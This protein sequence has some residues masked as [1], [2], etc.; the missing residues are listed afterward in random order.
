[1]LEHRRERSHQVV[2]QLPNIGNE[3]TRTALRKLNHARL[4]RLVE[5][6]HIEPVRRRIESLAF[7]LEVAAHEREASG[8]RLAHH[9]DVVAR[10][11]HRHPELQRLDGPLLS[12]HAKK[13]LQL[14]G[15]LE[16]ELAG[17][18]GTG[19]RI[20]RQAQ[21]GSDSFGH[22]KSLQEWPCGHN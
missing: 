19:Q 21:A 2:D 14:I 10:A 8:P 22:W 5:V 11:R 12:E 20:R 7:S 17:F 16:S 6:V 4:A 3:L 18:K 9:I 1:M 13:R 15:G